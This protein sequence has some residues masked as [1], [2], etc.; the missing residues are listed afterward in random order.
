M[1]Q[2]CLP[3]RDNSRT[4][5]YITAVNITEHCQNLFSGDLKIRDEE[6]DRAKLHLFALVRRLLELAGGREDTWQYRT[7]LQHDY[8]P[9]RGLILLGSFVGV[10]E[11]SRLQDLG[12]TKTLQLLSSCKAFEDEHLT[13]EALEKGTK[14]IA[15][16]HIDLPPVVRSPFQLSVL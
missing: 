15:G 14:L 9:A 1:V 16:L 6:G 8:T 4:I 11:S 7:C 5:H 12:T 3:L 10:P 13:E 2:A